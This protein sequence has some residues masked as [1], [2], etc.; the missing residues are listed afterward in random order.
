MSSLK[1]LLGIDDKNPLSRLAGDLVE[2]DMRLIESLIQMRKDS[3][4][5]QDQVAEILGRSQAS[6]AN[7]ERLGNDPRLSTIR[8]Y[9][10]AV[11]AHV[12]HDVQPAA[13]CD[14][15]VV[16]T[17]RHE[18]LNAIKVHL[19]EQLYGERKAKSAKNTVSVPELIHAA[20]GRSVTPWL[21]TNA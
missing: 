16:A 8:R 3:G 9:A 11:R 18:K 5:T 1:D 2:N 20:E 19:A 10:M 4:M 17:D 6:V 21:T 13:G 12:A 7:F 14:L 15:P